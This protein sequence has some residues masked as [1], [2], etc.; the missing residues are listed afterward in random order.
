LADKI[1]IIR[2]YGK[3]LRSVRYNTLP[4]YNRPNVG[5]FSS[6]CRINKYKYNI[7]CIYLDQ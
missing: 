6:Y 2:I 3:I 4:N 7:Y 1:R 5:K